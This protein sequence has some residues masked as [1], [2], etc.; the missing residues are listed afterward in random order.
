VTYQLGV[1]RRLSDDL[2]VFARLGYEAENGGVASRLAPTDGSTSIGIGGSYTIDNIEFTG[3]IEYAR[4][5]DAVDGSGTV[6]EDNS[7]LGFGLTVGFS[8]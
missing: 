1:G 2:S 8:F 5:G 4:L 3:G 6:Y 7:A